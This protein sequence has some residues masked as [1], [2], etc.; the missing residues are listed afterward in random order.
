MPVLA[1][2]ERF[3]DA[4]NAAWLSLPVVEAGRPVGS[5]SRYELMQRVYIKPFGRELHGRRPVSLLMHTEPL[6]LSAETS[7]ETASRYISARIRQPI[8]EDFIVVDEQGLY[9]GAGKV[10]D[11][12][13]AMEQ[14]VAQRSTE[15]ELAYNKLKSSQ[16][17]LIQSEKMASLGQ[18]VAGLAHEINTPL[19]YVR[20]NVEMTHAAL[21]DV[22]ALIESY[23]QVVD[24]V[25]TGSD[26]AEFERRALTL[27]LRRATVDA[28]ALDDLRGLLDDTVF[29]VGQIAD[30]VGNLK[31]FS[32]L[33]QARSER[34][35]VHKLIREH[36]R[37]QPIIMLTAKSGDAD[38][39]QGLTLG[40][41]DYVTK[42]FSVAQ[43]VLRVQAV[44]RRTRVSANGAATILLADGIEVDTRNMRAEIGAC[45]VRFTRC[46]AR[47][48]C[49]RSGAMREIWRSR[50]APWISTSPNCAANSKPTP[51]SQ[52]I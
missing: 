1:V 29:G 12:L 33:D 4:G 21:G 34:V 42:P 48:C 45:E 47:S 46:H 36:D 50:R 39:I 28:T 44:L 27:D 15:L 40:A 6:V 25:L 16:T 7:I 32:R 30:L 5:V 10:L 17:Q 19:G 52:S 11:V 20:N 43:L 24:A 2:G 18:M 41:D 51:S 49:T 37:E 8:M 31:D 9:L 14:Q 38:I 13:G 35:D 22:R 3:L 23:Q 26:P